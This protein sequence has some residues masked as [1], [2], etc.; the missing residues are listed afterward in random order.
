MEM[1]L[2]PHNP[3]T[4]NHIATLQAQMA[5]D[6]QRLNIR[7]STL[8]LVLEARR[9]PVSANGM[10]DKMP[11]ADELVA[12]AKILEAFIFEGIKPPGD[13]PKLVR[14]QGVG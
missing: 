10:P 4:N 5:Y 6:Q 13:G 7:A 11:T 12:E 14:V 1:N 3:P 2:A 8:Q 9:S